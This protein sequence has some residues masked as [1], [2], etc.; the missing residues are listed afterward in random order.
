MKLLN[1]F[2]G[3]TTMPEQEPVSMGPRCRCKRPQLCEIQMSICIS[4]LNSHSVK[5]NNEKKGWLETEVL[6]GRAKGSSFL[7]LL[8]SLTCY[9]Q[10]L[11]WVSSLY[12]LF[13]TFI[14][15]LL[16]VSLNNTHIFVL[17]WL[18]L[19]GLKL[20]L[21]KTKKTPPHFLK[22]MVIL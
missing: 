19:A 6:S 21:K 5:S 7:F 2:S 4:M 10:L 9:L 14:F 20:S 1:V 11:N 16:S 12:L 17:K 13:G 3:P 22:N 8:F 15:P 18:I